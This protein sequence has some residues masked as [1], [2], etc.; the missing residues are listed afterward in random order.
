MYETAQRR[1]GALRA[2]AHDHADRDA[3]DN[4]YAPGTV[5][6]AHAVHPHGSEATIA[7]D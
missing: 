2:F 5:V 4:P 3:V 1:K 6:F 7:S